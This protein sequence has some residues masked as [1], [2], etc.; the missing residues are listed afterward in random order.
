MSSQQNNN[1]GKSWKDKYLDSLDQQERQ[2]KQ[3]KTL[4]TLLNQAALRISMIA[5]GMDKNLDK[6][7]VGMRGL[8][9]G[10]TISA[11]ELKTVVEALGGQVKRM[12]A[13]KTDRGQQVALAFNHLI[14]QLQ[15]LRPDSDNKKA[16]KA[17]QKVAKKRSVEIP[18]Y[19]LLLKEFGELQQQVLQASAS[20]TPRLSLWQR[21]TGGGDKANSTNAVQAELNQ[22]EQTEQALG[23]AVEPEPEQ[24]PDAAQALSLSNS[25][26][27]EVVPDL[28]RVGVDKSQSLEPGFAK[29]NAAVCE[30]LSEL[31]Q[32]IEPPAMALAN[33]EK[34]VQ[35]IEQGLNWY[36]LVAV[37]EQVSIVIV[38]AFDRDQQ[39]FENFL[40]QLNDR[41]AS[42]YEII[43]SSQQSQ[44]DSQQAQ[45][46]LQASM[47][48][49]VAAMQDSVAN[50]DDLEQLKL[51]VS[52]RL[53]QV[54][55]VM[56]KHQ[57]SEQT[58]EQNLSAQL[59]ALVEQVKNMEQ[60]SQQAEQQIEEQR[61]RAL[62]D[63]LT[64]LPNREAYNQHLEQEY[65]RW[66]RYQRPLSLVVCD[67]D[68][69][70]SINDS[71][72]HQAGDKVLR[73]VARSIASRL[74]KS[75]FIAR[76]GGEE[77]VVLMPETDQQAAYQVIDHLREAIAQCPFH[78]K[79]QPVTITLSFGVTEF[80]GEDK[81]DAAFARADKALYQAKHEGRNRVI[82]AS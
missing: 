16:L 63:V 45:Q 5:E 10:K 17:F 46:L 44:G 60:Q 51:E 19:P 6:Q 66:R 64:Q 81:P 31:L 67:I 9:K 47:R 53:D 42:A 52:D 36:E 56:S 8:L 65:E 39:A 49:Q 20:T 43:N 72:G 50:A 58:R 71:Y 62:R 12:D 3:F 32:Q 73:I 68:H 14:A 28:P 26:A 78:F 77:F 76:F 15:Q 18:F 79:E 61:Q 27:E 38:S 33:Y 4:L 41:L 25:A 23:L 7:L 35:Q 34:A 57:G 70:K 54:L 29:I 74:R 24:K 1:A 11:K 22:T 13:I 69:F 59:N 2:D 82:V 80:S 48:E 21:L 40:K 37:L 30:I 55:S 75:D